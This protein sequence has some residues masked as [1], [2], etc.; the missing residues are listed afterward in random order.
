MR[1]A[2]A[3]GRGVGNASRIT[4][5]L[6]VAVVGGFRVICAV[7]RLSI[8]SIG[9]R[10]LAVRRFRRRLAKSELRSDEVDQLAEAYRDMV[11]FARLF[12]LRR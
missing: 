4:S 7:V 6:V 5:L 3:I 10:E 2:R 9:R 12:R 8:S 11:R 1:S